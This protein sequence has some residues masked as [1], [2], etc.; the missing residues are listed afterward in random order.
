M[1]RRSRPARARGLPRS[2]ALPPGKAQSPV[3][4]ETV[5][6]EPKWLRT[7]RIYFYYY[8]DYYYYHYTHYR[9]YYHWP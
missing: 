5:A 6:L 3:R 4:A 1:N 7:S 9:Y 8:Y 2:A